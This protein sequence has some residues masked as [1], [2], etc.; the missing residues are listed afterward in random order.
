[1]EEVDEFCCLGNVLD[2]EAGLERAL[3]ARVV[4]A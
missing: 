3:R 1:M 4:A 2:C